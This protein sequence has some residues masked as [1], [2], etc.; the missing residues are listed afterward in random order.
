VIVN[1][2]FNGFAD[3]DFGSLKTSYCENKPVGMKAK[4]KMSTILISVFYD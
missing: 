4:K 2:Y 3:E 1:L